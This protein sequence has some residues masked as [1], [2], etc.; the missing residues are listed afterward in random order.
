M[1]SDEAKPEW[2]RNGR[3]STLA[4]LI[5]NDVISVISATIFSLINILCQKH[6][7][8]IIEVV[9]TITGRVNDDDDV[10]ERERKLREVKMFR[11]D[12]LHTL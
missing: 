7:N 5:H 3:K 10:R 11:G 1:L 9:K 4:E 8:N 6:Y 2:Y 12:V